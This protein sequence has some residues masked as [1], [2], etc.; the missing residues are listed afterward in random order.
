M[1]RLPDPRGLCAGLSALILIFV[2][3]GC[4]TVSCSPWATHIAQHSEL[5]S[6]VSVIFVDATPDIGHLGRLPELT[7]YFQSSGVEAYYFDPHV[8]GDEQCLASLIYREKV[9]RGRQV[10]VVGWSYGMVNAL[11]ALKV[12][13]RQCVRVDTLVSLDCY[14]LNFHRGP[15]L[16]PSNVDRVVLIYREGSQLPEGFHHPVV[17]RVD[18]W[19]HLKMPGHPDTVNTLFCETLRAGRVQNYGMPALSQIQSS[20][21]CHIG[22]RPESQASFAVQQAS[23]SRAL[24]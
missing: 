23:Q 22:D 1:C 2:S 7:E 14:L 17:Y 8:H 16:Q 15:H 24:R 21:D 13:E 3:T 19:V 6:N 10:V 9:R 11:D 18:N 20:E 5:C 4:A 12:L